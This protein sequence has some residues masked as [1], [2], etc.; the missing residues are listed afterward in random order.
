MVSLFSIWSVSWINFTLLVL[1]KNY[2]KSDIYTNAV[3]IIINQSMSRIIFSVV[4]L[5][6]FVLCAHSLKF[7][8]SVDQQD[9][10]KCFYQSLST[11][12]LTQ[13]STKNIFSE[14]LQRHTKAIAW[15]WCE[16]KE[17]DGNKLFKKL[18][19]G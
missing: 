9:G 5:F 1:N 16:A 17:I 12:A 3:S 13:P 15:T 2:K 6:A 11:Q 8:V 19:K 4:L 14:S 18:A 7:L 10:A